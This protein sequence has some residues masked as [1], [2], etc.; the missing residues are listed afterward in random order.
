[1]DPE[2]ESQLDRELQELRD[3]VLQV[4]YSC[5]VAAAARIKLAQAAAELLQWL[6]SS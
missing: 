5:F 1:M 4:M 3:Q 6:A 2:Q